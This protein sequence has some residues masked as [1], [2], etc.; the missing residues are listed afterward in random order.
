MV[1]AVRIRPAEPGDTPA[2]REL[3]AA[4]LPLDPDAAALPGLL[5][6]APDAAQRVTLIGESA[7]RVSGA[8]FGS[9]R[10]QADGP[11]LGYLDLLAVAPPARGQGTGAA[12]L[13]AAEQELAAGG[14]Q[15][16]RL[17]GNPPLYVWPGV[18]SRYAALVALAGRAGYERYAE[19]LNM[20][21]DLTAGLPGTDPLNTAADEARLAG[22]GITVRRAAAAEAGP[23]GSWLTQGPWGGSSWP[24]EA[25][26][27]L[28]TGPPG[29]HI[30]ERAGQYLGFAS[31]TVNRRG[32]FG[33]MG[34][35][36]AERRR[37]IGAVLLKRCLADIRNSG[38]D[39]AQI[40]WTGPVQFYA[41][42]VGAVPD[43]VF[44]LYRKGQ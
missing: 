20:A 23:L 13:G 3:C 5:L 42:A 29:C 2:L 27:S 39:S 30:A 18:D 43:R 21:V 25:L 6:G 36:D 38:L 35:L 10:D 14:A 34:T 44:W 12:L 1:P 26:R 31:H 33:P 15:G 4:S 37:G 8:V 40:G 9:L 22:D 32:W 19:A 24:A 28:A 17:A 11:V 41:R 7:G 16:F